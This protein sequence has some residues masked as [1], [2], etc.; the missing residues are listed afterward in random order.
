[1]AA[2]ALPIV[3]TA[4]RTH[5]YVDCSR[6]DSV[7]YF[8]DNPCQTFELVSSDRF[9]SAEEFWAAETRRMRDAGWH[10]SA[11]Q[12][13]DYD[14]SDNGMASRADSWVV[15]G[16]RTAC[17]YVVTDREGMAAEAKALFPYDP[18]DNPHGVYVFYSRAK[19]ANPKDT[20]WV[21]LRP[22]NRDGRC[23]D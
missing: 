23:I 7:A 20:L 8:N 15:R 21:R 6:V 22:P 4:H 16:H 1:M 12:V 9:G 2:D 5:I 18:Y 19:V 17:A 11:P 3:L 14:S 10:H 13:V